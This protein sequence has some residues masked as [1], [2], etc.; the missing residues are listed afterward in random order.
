MNIHKQRLIERYKHLAAHSGVDL[1][2]QAQQAQA[3]K[4]T[5]ENAMF[6]ASIK[7]RTRWQRFIAWLVR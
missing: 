4:Q 5:H 7:P 2:K 1:E 6:W 3:R